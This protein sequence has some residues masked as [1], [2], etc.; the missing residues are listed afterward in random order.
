MHDDTPSTPL[1]DD[2]RAATYRATG[3]DV[4]DLIPC[5]HEAAIWL[6]SV[7]AWICERCG[8]EVDPTLSELDDLDDPDSAPTVDVDDVTGPP[9]A[10][11]DVD[12]WIGPGSWP[13]D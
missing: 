10:V 8:L 5:E 7:D 1:F 4:A 9:P 2:L 11:V 12:P 3:A 6:E 13:R